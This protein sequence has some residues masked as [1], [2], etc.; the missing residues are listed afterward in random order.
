VNEFQFTNGG[1]TFGSAQIAAGN[2]AGGEQILR[3]NNINLEFDF[4][5]IGFETAQVTF[6][7]FKQGGFE[8]LLVNGEAYVGNLAQAK[9]T[10]GGVTV[11]V[12]E[13]VLGSGRRGTV[14]LRGAVKTL[15][16][17]GQEFMLDNVCAR[18]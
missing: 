15:T 3:V 9:N 13:V 4:R 11:S 14:L 6:D 2:F 17:G 8:N 18:V 1:K 12:S 16:V 10:L 5:R 7:Y